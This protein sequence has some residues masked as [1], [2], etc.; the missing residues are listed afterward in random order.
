MGS[1]KSIGQR[2]WGPTR[3]AWQVTT[4]SCT[5]S[6]PNHLCPA[7]LPPWQCVGAL[8]TAQL[9]DSLAAAEPKP[10]AEMGGEEREAALM[11]HLCAIHAVQDQSASY[12]QSIVSSSIW[13][14]H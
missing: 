7:P 3:C 6:L 9:L 10:V 5:F 4:H 13:G 1:G 8:S 2:V 11:A 12:V 14:V